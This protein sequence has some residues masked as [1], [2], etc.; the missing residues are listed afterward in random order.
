MVTPC[1]HM[2][3]AISQMV[4][5]QIKANSAHLIYCT[6]NSW[7]LTYNRFTLPRAILFISENP[8]NSAKHNNNLLPKNCALS[9]SRLRSDFD[10]LDRSARGPSFAIA[11]FNLLWSSVKS[12]SKWQ[13]AY[14]I[15]LPWG[16]W[17]VL[18]NEYSYSAD[19]RQTS[20]YTSMLPATIPRN[21]KNFTSFDAF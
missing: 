17:H 12:S 15:H 16:P 21:Q 11:S 8:V 4:L 20:R 1:H 10:R 18:R 13:V 2:S 14:S 9:N 6:A 7:G 5:E 19:S 3:A